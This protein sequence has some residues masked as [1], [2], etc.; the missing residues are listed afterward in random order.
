[1]NDLDW[2]PIGVKPVPPRQGSRYG[3]LCLFFFFVKWVLGQNLLCISRY[4]PQ[5]D[6]FRSKT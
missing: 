4:G 5:S 3:R 2:F 6:A 1:M